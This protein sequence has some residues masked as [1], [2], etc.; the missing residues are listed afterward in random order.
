MPFSDWPRAAINWDERLLIEFLDYTKTIEDEKIFKMRQQAAW[1][2][3]TYFS[4][5]DKIIQTTIEIV[6]DRI[7]PS[8]ARTIQVQVQQIPELI[9]K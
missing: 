4:S 1:L 8:T 2:Y 7:F 6:H 9:S 5:I 3:S